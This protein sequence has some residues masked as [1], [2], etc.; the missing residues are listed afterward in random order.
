[1]L[2]DSLFESQRQHKA[3]N[4]LTAAVSVLAH[5]VTVIALLVIPMLQTQAVMLPEIDTT[6]F[7]PQRIQPQPVDVF[8]ATQPRAQN[9]I[10]GAD[11][12]PA[13]SALT[14]PTTISDEIARVN[15]SISL[16]PSPLPPGNGRGLSD[17]LG[18]FG[19]GSP[20]VVPTRPSG[21]PAPAPPALS[22]P[23]AIKAT[24][25]RQGGVAQAAMLIHQVKPEYPPLAKVTRTQGVV[26]LDAVI[27]K[28]GSIQSLRVIS[29]HPLLNQAALD[30][31]KQWKYRPTLLNGEPVEVSTTI[32]VTFTLQR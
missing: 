30:A 28:E 15:D 14:P 25:I 26:L 11:T 16:A 7:L 2:E 1:M 24:P 18:S 23:P 8:S 22:P 4:P 17:I 32:T 6:L 21:P 12:L 31:V 10:S 3:R 29:G 20:G 5:V 19:D 27:D 13:P 9:A